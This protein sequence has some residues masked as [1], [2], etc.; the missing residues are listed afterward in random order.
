MSSFVSWESSIDRAPNVTPSAL[1]QSKSKLRAKLD[2]FSSLLKKTGPKNWEGHMTTIDELRAMAL[3]VTA[4]TDPVYPHREFFLSRVQAMLPYLGEALNE[5][6]VRSTKVLH[7]AACIRDIFKCAAP[8]D[9]AQLP[10]VIREDGRMLDHLMALCGRKD[11]GPIW[12]PAAASI[13]AIISHSKGNKG[14]VTVARKLITHLTGKSPVA[15]PPHSREVWLQCLTRAVECW[16]WRETKWEARNIKEVIAHCVVD[17][18]MSVR[19]LAEDL[20]LTIFEKFPSLARSA[21]AGCA[22]SARKRMEDRMNELQVNNENS[23]METNSKLTN[24]VPGSARKNRQRRPSLLRVPLRTP[25]GSAS[26]RKRSRSVTTGRKT[27]SMRKLRR[28]RSTA[29][30]I[31]ERKTSTMVTSLEKEE[32]ETDMPVSRLDFATALT[33]SDNISKEKKGI[34]SKEN[35]GKKKLIS[36]KS[37]EARED[38]NDDD[39]M[40]IQQ[41][42]GFEINEEDDEDEEFDSDAETPQKIPPSLKETDFSSMDLAANMNLNDGDMEMDLLADDDTEKTNPFD[43]PHRTETST[44]IEFPSDSKDALKRKR[45]IDD[46]GVSEDDTMTKRQKLESMSKELI[47]WKERASLSEAE[48]EGFRVRCKN[49]T[50]EV[51]DLEK[52]GV[53]SFLAWQTQRKWSLVLEARLNDMEHELLQTKEENRKLLAENK[54]MENDEGIGNPTSPPMLNSPQ[55]TPNR[56]DSNA[57]GLRR[58]AR[59]R[60]KKSQNCPLSTSS[61]KTKRGCKSST[62]KTKRV[63]T[64]LTN[65]PA[66]CMK[67]QQMLNNENQLILG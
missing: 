43:P 56:V 54:K 35:A 11:K 55:P 29:S 59:L 44:F 16:D 31:K 58:S 57:N 5:S 34:S 1:P 23:G 46:V 15:E 30:L 63:F 47:S 66:K 32:N 25:R 67:R 18:G 39:T 12:M 4:A 21:A 61:K 27:R 64:D 33:S 40:M 9:Q 41:K 60:K 65:S 8:S 62:K 26:A 7:G 53:Q 51:E 49:L 10:G 36:Q 3:S 14:H 17:K 19:R 22:T 20:C 13:L 50:D 45:K 2:S 28:T 24:E 42:S 48:C 38:K 37:E 6:A 52:E